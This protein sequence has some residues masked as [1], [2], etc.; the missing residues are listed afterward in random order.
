M[1]LI[2]STQCSCKGGVVTAD[3]G[4]HVV[5]DLVVGFSLDHR[6]GLVWKICNYLVNSECHSL[7]VKGSNFGALGC[8]I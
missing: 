2:T 7:H 4:P 8:V 3:K 1:P 5:N 6:E